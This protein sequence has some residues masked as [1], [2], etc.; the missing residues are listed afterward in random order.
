ME[1][2]S[3]VIDA[4]NGTRKVRTE[5]IE[6]AEVF[7]VPITCIWLKTSEELAKHMN[8]YREAVTK[9]ERKHVPEVAYRMYNKSFEDPDKAEGFE[10][11]IHWSRGIQAEEITDRRLFGMWYV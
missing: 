2:K 10:K 9:G 6:V 1:G 5:W 8:R 7:K 3:V 11:V 4:T